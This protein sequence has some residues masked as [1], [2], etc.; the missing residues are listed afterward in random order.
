MCIIVDA[1]KLGSFLAD[2]PDEDSAPIREWLD[3]GGNLVYST[4]STFAR[5][6]VGRAKGRLEVYV[7]A[8]K[9][10]VIPEERFIDDER[11]LRARDRRSDDP[12]V[13]A[14]AKVSGVRL[15]YSGDNDLIADFKDKRFIDNPR[16]KVYS[17]AANANLLTRSVCAT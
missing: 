2:P 16:G 6:I 10:I 7:R 11:C 15:L 8:G 17:G 9:A 5:E 1:N 14:L 13:L 4:G 12:H 3:K